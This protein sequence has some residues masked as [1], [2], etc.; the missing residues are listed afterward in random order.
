MN[1]IK[2]AKELVKL[3]KSLVAEQNIANQEGMY[4]NFTGSIDWGGTNGTVTNASFKLKKQG[5]W[6]K[7]YWYDG[8]WE[9]GYAAGMNWFDGIW[10]RGIWETGIWNNGTWESGTW[11]HGYWHNGTWKN[12][13]WEQGQW[14]GGKWINGNWEYGISMTN[15][16]TGQQY[17]VH[18]KN[19]SPDKWEK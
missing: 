16:D 13:T 19:D 18:E 8:V 4:E 7:I 3:A 2:V 14:S 1:K 9:N 5:G 15:Y 11:K 17:N 6:Q 12:G 10:K